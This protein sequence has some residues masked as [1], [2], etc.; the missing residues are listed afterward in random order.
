[1][2]TIV[3]SGKDDKGVTHDVTINVTLNLFNINSTTPS[4]IDLA[5]KQVKTFRGM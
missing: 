4:T 1:M 2:A 5:G 3:V